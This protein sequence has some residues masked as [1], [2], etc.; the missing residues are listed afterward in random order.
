[1]THH[2]IRRFPFSRF[3]H[4]LFQ[5]PGAVDFQ[6][7]CSELRPNL[8][9]QETATEFVVQAEIPGVAEKD[10]QVELKKNV[11][12]I[13]GEIPARNE[14]DANLRVAE[15]R[16]GKFLRAMALPSP[17]QAENVTASLKSG[18]LE[19]RLPKEDADRDMRV[20]PVS[21]GIQ[22]ETS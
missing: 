1:M 20:I 6:T 15:L 2:L 9:L 10:V 21:G 7:G 22:T 16:H 3:P 14:D 13:T 5:E 8:N 18:I 11:L 19:I 12:K 17:V 4:S